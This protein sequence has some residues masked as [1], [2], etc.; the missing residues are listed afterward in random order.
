[1]QIS[2]FCAN[3]TNVSSSQT[4]GFSGVKKFP[5]EPE[6]SNLIRE[7]SDRTIFPV[8]QQVKKGWQALTGRNADKCRQL[9]RKGD[10]FAFEK[11]ARLDILA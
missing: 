1:M 9:Q 10:A 6:Y 2:S 3:K 7:T 4:V 8:I 11:A 5:V